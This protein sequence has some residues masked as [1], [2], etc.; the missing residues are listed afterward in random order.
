MAI[1]KSGTFTPL[2]SSYTAADVVINDNSADIDFRVE[3][4]N[5]THMVFVDGGSDHVNIGT[6]TD[7]GG[8][9]NVQTTD[10][11]VNLVLV[12]TDTD[13]NEGP[14]LDLTRDAGN[15]PSDGDISGRIR[16]R[17]DN[18]NLDMTNY[19]EL[20]GVVSDVS[21]GTE[22][23]QL[24]FNIIDAGTLRNFAHM[25]GG[26]GTVF[27][28]DSNNIDF[29]VESDAESN[30]FRVQAS[31]GQVAVGSRRGFKFGFN[32]LHGVAGSSGGG[33][34]TIGYNVLF[35]GTSADFGTL[36]TDTSWRIDIG[37]NNRLQVHSR[38][39]SS[40]VSDGATFTAGPYVALNGTTWTD[41]SDA[42]LKENVSTITGADAVAK[43]KA[44]RPVNYSWIHDEDASNQ[45]GFI[46]QEM[47]GVVPEVVDLPD[48]EEDHYGIQYAKLVPMLTAALQEALTKIET[49]ESRIEALEL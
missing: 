39:S 1:N 47:V 18:T 22:D 30:A 17:N 19:I 23:G 43:V 12:C 26:S 21:D 27:N 13:G 20:T 33:Y 46:A 5:N 8:T 31:T 29:R 49:L 24:Q 7:H 45:I 2:I 14:I 36:T 9:L 16:F 40:P 32:E 4:N 3:S 28:E 42:R 48:D 41:G 44:M 38:S 25:T 15:V 10:N 37:N 34:P 6:S 35:T 11:S